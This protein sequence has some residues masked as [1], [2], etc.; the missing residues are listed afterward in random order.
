MSHFKGLEA[1][2]AVLIK[3]TNYR[4]IEHSS[5]N[6]TVTDTAC[7]LLGEKPWITRDVLDLCSERREMMKR[8]HEKEGSKNMATSI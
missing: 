5:T 2:K 8:R 7:E 1:L 6:K 4:K 3:G